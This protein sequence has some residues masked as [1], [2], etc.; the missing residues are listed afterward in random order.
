MPIPLTGASPLLE[1]R[2]QLLVG[3]EQSGHAID[4]TPDLFGE[5]AL[6]RLEEGITHLAKTGPSLFCPEF[7]DGDPSG[8]HFTGRLGGHR[9]G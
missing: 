3:G 6:P 9:R 5:R 7:L 8:V 2:C 1:L 4:E